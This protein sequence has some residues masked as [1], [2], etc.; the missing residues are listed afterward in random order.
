V[1]DWEPT[2]SGNVRVLN[3]TDD[4]YRFFDATPQTEFLY[5]CVQQAVEHELP[6]E[7]SFL[8]RYDA[9]RRELNLVVDMPER[10]FDLL[11]RFLR[12]NGGSLSRRGREKEFAALTDDEAARIET[13]YRDGFVVADAGA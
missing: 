1:V 9:F 7:V 3:D 13:I 4:F 2:D 10:L 12:R 5:G 11:F 8:E 6:G